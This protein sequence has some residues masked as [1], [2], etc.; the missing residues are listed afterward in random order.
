MQNQV[1]RMLVSDAKLLISYF[2]SGQLLEL[3]CSELIESPQEVG[4]DPNCKGVFLIYTHPKVKNSNRTSQLRIKLPGAPA[5]NQ[6]MDALDLRFAIYLGNAKVSANVI[7]LEE[8]KWFPQETKNEFRARVYLH[9]L[10]T[11]NR[12]QAI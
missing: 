9:A 1:E 12:L 6:N 11:R 3:S 2:T 4:T 10:E 5:R 8:L 7:T